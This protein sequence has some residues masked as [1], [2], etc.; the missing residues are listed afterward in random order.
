MPC[1]S[2]DSTTSPA[3][4]LHIHIKFRLQST[5]Q[6]F[7]G[8]ITGKKNQ[9]F[10]FGQERNC[11]LAGLI[12]SCQGTVLFQPL[13]RHATFLPEMRFMPGS[14]PAITRFYLSQNN[15]ENYLLPMRFLFSLFKSFFSVFRH[16]ITFF[17]VCISI[18]MW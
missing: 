7:S 14:Y 9:I 1:P 12:Y 3:W 6:E 17:C 4:L 8:S 18:N 15:S 5:C 16:F 2:Y 10:A 13:Q 11:S